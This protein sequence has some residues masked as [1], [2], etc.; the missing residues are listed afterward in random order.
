MRIGIIGPVILF[1]LVAAIAYGFYKKGAINDNITTNC[2]KTALYVI[3]N[4]GHITPVYN[5]KGVKV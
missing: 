1:L 3:G 5:C 4:K 2:V